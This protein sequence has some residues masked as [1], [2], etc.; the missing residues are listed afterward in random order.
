MLISQ[1]LQN[2]INAQVGREFGAS[3]QYV[4][5]ATY[6]DADSLPQLAAFFYRQA[7][8]EKMHAMKFV[9]Y[10]VDAGGQVRIPAVQGPKSD[11]ASA[12]EAVQAALDWELEV[13][14]QINALMDLA[15][16]QN[17]HIAQDFLR[18]FV[19]EQLE[20]VKTM[21]TLLR[22]VARAGENLLWVEDF[23]A[24]NP[25]VPAEGGETAA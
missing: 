24:R 20:E 18:W 14:R 23:L 10:V 15:I 2:S 7:E 11:F 1:E 25:I 21:D 5:I 9:H 3:L 13:T 17:D 16:K 4:N 22:V 12:K 6:F 8:E 19:T